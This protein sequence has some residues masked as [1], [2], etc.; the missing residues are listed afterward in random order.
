MVRR[1]QGRTDQSDLIDSIEPV[2]MPDVMAEV[3][4]TLH[5]P[6]DGGG[7]AGCRESI[8]EAVA[9]TGTRMSLDTWRAEL[10]GA[11]ERRRTMD[12]L[13]AGVVGAALLVAI[14]ASGAGC[15]DDDRGASSPATGPVASV[16]PT[17]PVRGGELP[18]READVMGF[19]G[20]GGEYPA[21]PHLAKATNDYYLGMG[22][23]RGDPIVRGADGTP[24]SPSE[25][26]EGDEVAVWIDGGCA[27]SFPVQCDIVAVVVTRRAS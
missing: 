26:E 18:D 2:E 17:S 1:L 11:Q 21:P 22:L 10:S 9:R 14:T 8:T 23:L 6:G 7:L 20:T 4:H 15:G 25:L 13:R 24:M 16:A 27:E 5:Q 3:E 12:S 19:V